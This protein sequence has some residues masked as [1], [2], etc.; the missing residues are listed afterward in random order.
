MDFF[1]FLNG[2]MSKDI[3][4]ILEGWEYVPAE[5][6]VRKIEGNDGQAKV[7]IRM[8]L[9]LMQLEWTGRPDASQPHGCASLL[10]Y[11]QEKYRNWKSEGRVGAFTLSRADCWVLAQEA[12]Q[13][14]WRRIG[15]FG[16]KEYERAEQDAEHNLAILDMCQ[17]FAEC[18]EDQQI[19]RHY[20][21]FVKAHRIQAR[22]LALLEHQDYD[23]ALA[24]I[25]EGIQE[26]EEILEQ[27]GQFEPLEESPELLYLREWEAEVK[28]ARPLSL[29]EQLNADLQAAVEQEKFELAASL[30]DRLRILGAASPTKRRDL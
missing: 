5:L 9:G 4:A 26:I 21:V 8:D 7:Q 25:R 20:R 30:R 2:R 29:K 18:E 27:Q 3:N 15:F 6:K 1:K 23:G 10:D 17:E 24:Q 22:A 16:L 12:L 19:A 13:Y 28:R 11:Y 14:Y